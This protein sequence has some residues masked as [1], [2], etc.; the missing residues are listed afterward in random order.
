M[1]APFTLPSADILPLLFTKTE[2]TVWNEPLDKL[3][4]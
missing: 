2:L 1:E 4:K 3:R